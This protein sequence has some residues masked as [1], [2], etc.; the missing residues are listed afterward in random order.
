MKFCLRV[1]LAFSSIVWMLAARAQPAA[2]LA[3]YAPP[4]P[5]PASECARWKVFYQDNR[6]GIVAGDA[7]V[8]WD[9]NLAGVQFPYGGKPYRRQTEFMQSRAKRDPR[10]R[11]RFTGACPDGS[12]TAAPD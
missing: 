1:F 9:Q 2:A 7:V 3:E 5:P 4:P 12:T 10:Y 11:F 6:L 8:D